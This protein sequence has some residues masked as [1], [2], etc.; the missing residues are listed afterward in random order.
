M[1]KNFLFLL[2]GIDLVIYCSQSKG[3]QDKQTNIG[4][5]KR[6]MKNKGIVS[7]MEVTEHRELMELSAIYGKSA[8]RLLIE[9]TLATLKFHRTKLI[10]T[11]AQCDE[12]LMLIYELNR[13]GNNLNQITHNLN[14]A[15]LVAENSAV[16]IGELKKV[17]SEIR[18]ETQRLKN[19]CR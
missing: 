10:L 8:G 12:I 13:I 4:L 9:T 18:I 2:K 5:R 3:R 19:L 7:R 6:I 1:K 14:V 11:V 15:N 17:I 16:N